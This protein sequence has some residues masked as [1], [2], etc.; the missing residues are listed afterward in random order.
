MHRNA[1]KLLLSVPTI[2][3][4]VPHFKGLTALHFAVWNNDANAIEALSKAGADISA[5]LD[6]AV[7]WYRHDAIKAFI[8]AG[9]CTK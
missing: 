4:D 8:E 6:K 9:V 2:E 3:P 5:P 1:I 7:V